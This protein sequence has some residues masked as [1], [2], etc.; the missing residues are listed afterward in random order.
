MGWLPLTG[1][2]DQLAHIT[3]WGL[4]ATKTWKEDR[5]IRVYQGRLGRT[6]LRKWDQGEDLG[7]S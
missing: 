6:K 4:L 3:S 1:P 5:K 2:A 7:L